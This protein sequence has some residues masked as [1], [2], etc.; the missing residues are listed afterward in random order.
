MKLTHLILFLSVNFSLFAQEILLPI[1]NRFKDQYILFEKEDAST[2]IGNGMFPVST[3]QV[4]GDIY[5]KPK[6]YNQSWLNRKL[7]NEHFIELRGEDYFLA[8]AP[9]INLNIGRERGIEEHNLFQNTRG[10]QVIGEVMNKVAFY[11]GF[12]E[13]QAKFASFQTEYFMERGERRANVNLGNYYVE[14]AAIPMGGRTKPF[15]IDE[16]D[17]AFDF[18][19]SMSYVRYVPFEALSLQIGNTPNFIGWGHR[20]M[21]LSDN[22]FNSTNFKIDYQIN[23]KLSYTTMHGKYFNLFRRVKGVDNTVEEPYEKK[24]Y[25]INYLSYQPTDNISIGLFQS[26]QFF[27]EDSVLSVPLN[28]LLFN[29]IIVLNLLADGFDS[30]KT[31][32]I[33]GINTGF[34]ITKK[35]ML[36]GQFTLDK[37]HQG[38]NKG[39]QLG[40]RSKNLFG[41]KN[42]NMQLEYNQADDHL[43]AASNWRLSYTHFN[44][45]IAHTLGNGFQELIFRI[46]YQYKNIYFESI[47]SRYNK[48]QDMTEMTNL[49]N[50]VSKGSVIN[51][52]SVLFSDVEIGY[53]FN[54]KTQLRAFGKVVYRTQINDLNQRNTGLIFVGIKTSLFNQYFDF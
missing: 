39:F 12:Y 1:N 18:A 22:S 4:G 46:N 5:S 21:L 7:F 53:L 30:Q 9:L 31:K 25:T 48:T 2:F 52:Q 40:W 50:S 27:R 16:L 29:P 11:T 28:P 20:S 24:N 19:Q 41:I 47:T 26:T 14:N 43:Y 8:I 49:F 17:N 3:N 15:K 42:L 45:P 23:D 54:P 33:L 10:F 32:S 37:N 51:N 13:N 44:L 35:Q 34:K 36:F 6:K 38:W